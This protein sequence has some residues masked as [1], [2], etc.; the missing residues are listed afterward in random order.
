MYDVM[1]KRQEQSIYRI[2]KQYDY[3]NLQ[4]SL[5]RKLLFR[6]KII[7]IIS[8]LLLFSTVLIVVLQHRHKKLQ[9]S[10]AEM[11]R[12]VDT[13]KE[14]LRQTVKTSVMEEE[15]ISRL[16][17]M[18]AA[19]RASKRAKDPQNEWKLLVKQV[20]NGKDSMF[21]AARDVIEMVYPNLYS[22]L[23][24]KYPNLTETETKI[25]LLSFC[26]ISN[27][28]M[29]ELL[30]LRQNTINQN[31]SNLRKKLNL[32]FDEMKEQLRDT[33]SNKA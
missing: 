3:E 14:D 5:N 27:V 22:I 28:E 23:M 9:D 25:C 32:D 11:K 29:A 19:N 10:E 33:L 2:Q 30:G 18:L 12:L 20:M 1:Q 7:L 13:M 26:D 8:I 15:V 24:E 31:R 17:M 16:N 21:E 4:N 6:H